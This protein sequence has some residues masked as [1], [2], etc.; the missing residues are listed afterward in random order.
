MHIITTPPPH[1]SFLTTLS[2]LLLP[3]S[4]F[5][6]YASSVSRIASHHRPQWPRPLPCH[7]ATNGSRPGRFGPLEWG[8]YFISGNQDAQLELR[9]HRGNSEF[10]FVTKN[11][12]SSTVVVTVAQFADN[13]VVYFHASDMTSKFARMNFDMVRNGFVIN[14]STNWTVVS[15]PMSSGIKQLWQT[16][17]WSDFIVA[18]GAREFEVHRA[19]L[20]PRSQYF[21]A[22]CRPE[23]LATNGRMRLEEDETTVE[24]LLTEMYGVE[25]DITGSIF[26]SFALKYEIG[27]EFV[28]MTLLR[29]FIAANKHNIQPLK[30]RTA[31]AIADRLLFIEDHLT[32]ASEFRLI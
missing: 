13:Q 31:G 32:I 8:S 25:N 28:V 3:P 12:K 16:K 23:F 4:S 29:L 22:A 19:I 6:G 14:G 26:T 24:T 9:L 15:D 20:C 7:P 5:F 10:G 1:S 18:A 21:Q 30:T 17:E 11:V 2:W 27:K